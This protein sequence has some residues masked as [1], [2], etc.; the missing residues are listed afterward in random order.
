MPQSG[1]CEF[2]TEKRN[3]GYVRV[4]VR[5]VSQPSSTQ[6]LGSLSLKNIFNILGVMSVSGSPHFTAEELSQATFR[7]FYNSETGYWLEVK[8]GPGFPPAY[9]HISQAEATRLE[10]SRPDPEFIARM[11]DWI[12]VPAH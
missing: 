11:F 6:Q 8:R 3:G 1:E 10:V 9:R 12:E 7:L 2:K 4:R 5:K